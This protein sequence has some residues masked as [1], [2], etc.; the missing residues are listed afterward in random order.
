MW[1]IMLM[2]LYCLDICRVNSFIISKEK[3]VV[4]TRNGFVLGQGTALNHRTKV[5]ETPRT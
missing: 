3:E 5:I 2:W 1:V 4:S